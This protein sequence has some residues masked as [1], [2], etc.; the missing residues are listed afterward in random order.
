MDLVDDDGVGSWSKS[1]SDESEAREVERGTLPALALLLVAVDGGVDS[2]GGENTAGLVI[3]TPWLLFPDLFCFDVFVELFFFAMVPLVQPW[4]VCE[5]E[6][7]SG[8]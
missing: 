3:L 4:Y 6:E 5:G 7:Q 2:T 8:E 1:A